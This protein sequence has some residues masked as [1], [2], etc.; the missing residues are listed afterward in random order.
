MKIW[1]LSRDTTEDTEYYG[2]FYMAARISSTLDRCP[3]HGIV[4]IMRGVWCG[5]AARFAG[6]RPWWFCGVGTNGDMVQPDAT[7]SRLWSPASSTKI[8]RTWLDTHTAEEVAARFP[9][10]FLV[11]TLYGQEGTAVSADGVPF[12]IHQIRDRNVRR[13]ALASYQVNL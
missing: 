12:C 6:D 7:H 4:W 11:A 10:D 8:L 13:V 5:V 9:A 3:A 1:G 2:T